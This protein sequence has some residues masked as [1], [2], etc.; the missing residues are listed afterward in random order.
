MKLGIAGRATP[1]N[2]RAEWERRVRWK[3]LDVDDLSSD[4]IVKIR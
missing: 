1:M 3:T 2:T 4:A